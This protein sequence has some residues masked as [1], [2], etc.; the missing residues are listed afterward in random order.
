MKLKNDHV[1]NDISTAQNGIHQ[2][3]FT[4]FINIHIRILGAIVRQL[5][6]C[7]NL[8]EVFTFLR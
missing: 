6:P 3:G 7:V 8:P 2:N 4:A 1:Q 5:C